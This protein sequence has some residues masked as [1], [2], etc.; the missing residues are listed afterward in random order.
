[1][2]NNDM[3]I[4]QTRFCASVRLGVLVAGV[5]LALLLSG[6]A[7]SRGGSIPYDVQSFGVPD[8]P[9]VVALEADYRIAPL[10]KLNVTVFQVPDLS[11]EFQVDL[12]G[13][14]GMPLIGN[15]RAVD[16]TTRELQQLLAQRLSAN[17]LRNPDVRVG[18]AESTRRN[19]TVEG[20][21]RQPGLFPVNGPLTLVQAIAMARGTDDM[22][23]PRRIA[24]FRTI[25]GRR[26]AAAFDLTS[27]RRGEAEDPAIYPGDIIVVDG[28]RVRAIQR[29]ILQTIPILGLFNP[30][31]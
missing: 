30:F 4:F 20:S 8:T 24:I 3:T 29:E 27:I 21:V 7:G 15:I 18:I 28:S 25:Q 16:L 31:L 12:T 1:M 6:C 14:I 13:H 2:A 17:Y 11:G 10:D 23:N 5:L 26:M 22:A 19:V 9:A